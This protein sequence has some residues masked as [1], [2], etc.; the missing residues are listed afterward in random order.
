MKS[1]L[2]VVLALLTLLTFGTAAE[3]DPATSACGQREGLTD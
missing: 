2:L 3:S 1:A